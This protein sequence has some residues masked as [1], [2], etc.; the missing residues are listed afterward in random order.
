VGGVA[1]G[2]QLLGALSYNS[3]QAT[4]SSRR[5]AMYNS[6]LFLALVLGVV[7]AVFYTAE[8]LRGG[9]TRWANDLCGAAMTLCQHPQWPAIAAGVLVCL[10]VVLK[11]A[12]ASR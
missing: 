2:E 8:E 12:S 3:M 10:V 6:G 4:R 5:Y 1:A 11:V 9:T 7:A